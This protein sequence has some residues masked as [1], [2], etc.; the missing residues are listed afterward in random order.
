MSSASGVI[1]RRLQ[2]EDDLGGF[3]CEDPDLDEFLKA[4][5]RRLE[6][7]WVTRVYVAVCEDHVVGYAALLADTVIL[8]SG[9]RRKLKLQH[10]DSKQIPALKIGRLAVDA[11]FRERTRG[12]GSGLVRHAFELALALSQSIGCRLLTVD[13]YEGSVAFYQKLGF[14]S[15]KAHEDEARS[16]ISMRLD[17]RSDPL[18]GWLQSN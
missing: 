18:P 7:Q 4:D 17:L 1:I 12:V 5:A 8:K 3:A 2:A 10:D 14:V 6:S 9:E 15:N 11:A 13:A 16:T